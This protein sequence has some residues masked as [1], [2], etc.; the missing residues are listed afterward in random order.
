MDRQT[1]AES[2]V[3]RACNALETLNKVDIAIFRDVEWQPRKLCRG[4]MN[5]FIGRQKIGLGILVIR[6][7]RLKTVGVSKWR[8]KF[9]GVKQVTIA[10][11]RDS[12]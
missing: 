7:V 6:K 1:L 4:K 5:A 2:R 9:R 12:C 8:T 3:S 10:I 11:M